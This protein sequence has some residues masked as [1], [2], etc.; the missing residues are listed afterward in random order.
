MKIAFM[1]HWYDPE[2]GSAATSGIIAR[3]LVRRGHEVHAVTGYPIYPEGKIFDGYRNRPYQREEIDGVIVHRGPIY[4]SHDTSAARRMANY[5]SFSASGAA[6]ALATLRSA[7]VGLVYSSPAT[8]AVP[9]MALA[10]L[11]RV[12]YVMQIQDLW[13]DTV[14]N[15]GFVSDGTGSALG[16]ALGMY[17]GLTY[18]MA[19]TVAVTSPGMADILADRGVPREKLAYVPNWADE[20]NFR[21]HDKDEALKA[22]LGLRRPFIAMYAGNLGEMQALDTILDAASQLRHRDEIGFALVGAGVE[23]SRLRQRVAD[24]GID[25]VTFVPSQPFSRMSD[26]LAVGDVQLATLKDVPLFRST[27]PSKIQA[28]FAAGRP[29]IAAIGGDA[30]RIINEAGAGVAT[31]PGDA[32]ELARAVES[33]AALSP[34][35]RAAMGRTARTYYDTHF[36]E[37]VAGDALETLLESARRR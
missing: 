13:P 6:V 37:S 5:L 25:N 35:E 10:A 23:E 29:V 17:C 32:T 12:P 22:D 30:A 20:S 15:S 9:G 4:P 27:T 8:A 14:T 3:A 36:S 33:M 2:G 18:R 26:V 19:T 28:N 31:T 11:G 21:P 16:R 34:D 7:D 1:T 24:E